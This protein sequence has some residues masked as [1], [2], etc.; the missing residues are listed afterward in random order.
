MSTSS[1]YKV[2][3]DIGLS[4]PCA[5]HLITILDKEI[6]PNFIHK[7]ELSNEFETHMFTGLLPNI[8]DDNNNPM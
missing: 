2:Y 5:R 4:H 1:K 6:G 8:C 3:G 7:T